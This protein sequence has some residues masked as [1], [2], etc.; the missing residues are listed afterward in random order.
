MLRDMHVYLLPDGEEYVAVASQGRFILYRARPDY[1][2]Q[3]CVYVVE[4]DGTVTGSDG[5]CAAFRV[6]ELIDTGMSYR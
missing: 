1:T 5:G 2:S 3:P 6:E 4:R